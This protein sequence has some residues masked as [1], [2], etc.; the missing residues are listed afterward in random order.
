MKTFEELIKEQED[1]KKYYILEVVRDRKYELNITCDKD[2]LL[3]CDFI[4]KN[5]KSSF[6]TEHIDLIIDALEET[7]FDIVVVKEEEFDIKKDLEKISI[8]KYM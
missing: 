5:V 1:W 3:I 2:L 6:R 7:I 4:Y 8:F